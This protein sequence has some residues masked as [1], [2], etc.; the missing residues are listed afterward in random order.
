MKKIRRFA[1]VYF[2]LQ[3]AAVF[4][5]WILLFFFPASR[6][7]FQMGESETIL[8]A[9]WLPDLFLLAAGSLVVSAYCFSDS[10]FL[11]LA[12]WFFVGAISYATFYCLAF[13]LMTDSGWL[14]VTLMFPA[15]ILTGNFAIGLS[16]PFT[17][18]MFRRSDNAK[19]GWLLIKTF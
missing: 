12:L 4:V 11:S 1:T 9:F 5:W 6:A 14:G 18:L 13:A 7:Y 2:A 10:K 16:T 8:L 15:M 19:T 17:D 3:G